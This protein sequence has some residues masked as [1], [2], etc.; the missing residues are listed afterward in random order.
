MV[1]IETGL[2]PEK[3][4]TI[5]TYDADFDYWQCS[6]CDGWFTLFEGTPG[7]NAYRYCPQCG[8]EI[9][10]YTMP[11]SVPYEPPAEVEP[12]I[13]RALIEAHERA[14]DSLEVPAAV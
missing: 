1:D 6:N 3:N 10:E 8:F 12:E 4:R 13:D 9:D 11:P 2:S 7:E 14:Y 5:W